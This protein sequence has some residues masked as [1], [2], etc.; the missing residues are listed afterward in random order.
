[1]RWTVELC[2]A[3]NNGWGVVLLLAAP[4]VGEGEPDY[5]TGVFMIDVARVQVY[6]AGAAPRVTLSP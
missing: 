4:G 5:L 6:L 3:V 2:R 1:M